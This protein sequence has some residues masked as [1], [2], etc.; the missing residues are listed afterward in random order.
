MAEKSKLTNLQ[1]EANNA[2]NFI[3]EVMTK[4]GVELGKG[5][6]TKANYNEALA[7]LEKLGDEI[8]TLYDEL[9]FQIDYNKEYEKEADDKRKQ[10]E[11]EYLAYIQ[12]CEDNW[13]KTLER[14][15]Q[16]NK[17]QMDVVMK[18]NSKLLADAK[19]SHD[20]EGIV[21][22]VQELKKK[23]Q[24]TESE[25]AQTRAIAE[26]D[27]K[28]LNEAEERI[29]RLNEKLQERQSTAKK[30]SQLED[31]KSRATKRIADLNKNLENEK[32][33]KQ[34][35]ITEKEESERKLLELE[36]EIEKYKD[37]L[38]LVDGQIDNIKRNIIQDFLCKEFGLAENAR[39]GIERAKALNK[40]MKKAKHDKTYGKKIQAVVDGLK[41]K[42]PHIFD[43]EAKKQ[44][45]VNNSGSLYNVNDFDN[46]ANNDKTLY[47]EVEK[48]LKSTI[49]KVS[50][51]LKGVAIG[52]VA[53]V[54]V[55]SGIAGIKFYND[56]G[57]M[58]EKDAAIAGKDA[59]IAE[60]EDAIEETN[61][62]YET[63]VSVN[64]GLQS[65]NDQLAQENEQL[66]QNTEMKVP[67]KQ[68]FVLE[69][70]QIQ[71]QT[72]KTIEAKTSGEIQK[73]SFS[74][75]ALT[76]KLTMVVEVEKGEKTSL[77]VGEAV[78]N[79]GCKLDANSVQNYVEGMTLGVYDHKDSHSGI[80]Y[81][82]MSFAN[83]VQQTYSVKGCHVEY[84]SNGAILGIV[85]SANSKSGKSVDKQKVIDIMVNDILSQQSTV[86]NE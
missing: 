80:Y 55:V 17:D 66:K 14:I 68:D 52:A 40:A 70:N 83:S 26:E 43:E 19:K 28:K 42:Y 1:R 23:L 5:K 61:K 72:L 21:S 54:V 33:E 37:E 31:S 13:N 3:S 27:G 36:E 9:D 20:I 57:K 22:Q 71:K 74:Y 82:E 15:E 67:P 7:N 47:N 45:A 2:A 85:Y 65:K 30:L 75:D 62:R 63:Q 59:T 41:E 12:E 24:E 8:S 18:Y 29:L 51:V 76:G 50:K 35:A 4:L 56:H 73:I 60:Q 25:L 78:I 6:I 69:N 53:L 81:N 77:V 16:E 39:V 44:S 46:D 34:K 79:T 58:A 10:L 49:Y 32:V 64:S 11:E 48:T 86:E 38:I 84:D